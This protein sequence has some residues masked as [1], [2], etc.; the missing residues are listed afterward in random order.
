[1]ATSKKLLTEQQ[2]YQLLHIYDFFI[3]N[4]ISLSVVAQKTGIGRTTLSNKFQSLNAMAIGEDPYSRNRFTSEDYDN[5]NNF[6]SRLNSFL[7]RLI[8]DRVSST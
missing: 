7:S 2:E 3:D 5:I 6:L 8:T 1:M 4:G